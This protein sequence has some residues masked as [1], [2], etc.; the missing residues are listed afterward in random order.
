MSEMF[1]HRRRHPRRLDRNVWEFVIRDYLLSMRFWCLSDES[2]GIEKPLAKWLIDLLVLND[3]SANQGVNPTAMDE[4]T[5]QILDLRVH[6]THLL[7]K[8]HFKYVWS[9][10]MT[11]DYLYLLSAIGLREHCL[12]VSA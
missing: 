11:L 9:N 6:I 5:S 2:H 4:A 10:P 1:R 8:F 3:R 7:Q 12:Q